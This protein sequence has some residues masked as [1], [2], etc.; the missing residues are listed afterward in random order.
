MRLFFANIYLSLLVVMLAGIA[1][2]AIAAPC[3]IRM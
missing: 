1:E 3:E 2:M